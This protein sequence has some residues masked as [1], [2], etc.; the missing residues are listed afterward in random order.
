MSRFFTWRRLF[1]YSA[2]FTGVFSL[3]IGLFI[4]QQAWAIHK[5]VRLIE[6]SWDARG[7]NY[8]E[9]SWI[10]KATHALLAGHED[11]SKYND[12][13]W[14]KYDELDMTDGIFVRA[15]LKTCEP[16]YEPDWVTANAGYQKWGFVM[17]RTDYDEDDETWAKTVR[18][19]NHSIRAHLE[20]EATHDGAECDP[21]LVRDRAVL[22]IIEDRET[23]NGADADTVRALWRKRVDDG[24]VDKS[25]KMGGWNWGWYR[26]N[27]SKGK[28]RGQDEGESK[29]EEEEENEEIPQANGLSLNLCLM[30]DWSARALMQLAQGGLPAGG[31]RDPW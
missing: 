23:L 17:Y 2:Y 11:V 9:Y 3:I 18:H 29:A 5:T 1:V 7:H 16:G 10:D 30:Y 31:P 25:F 24:L 21:E 12:I 15:N 14:A 28:S 20:I 27:L 13:F 19:I 8:S 4:S 26:V 6:K 22:E